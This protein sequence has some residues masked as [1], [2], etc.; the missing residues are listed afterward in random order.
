MSKSKDNSQLNQDEFTRIFEEYRAKIDAIT[1]RTEKNLKSINGIIDVYD[2]PDT[3][4]EVENDIIEEAP[5]IIEPET[6]RKP[7][8]VIWPSEKE[9]VEII[10]EA[11]RKAQQIISEAEERIKKEAKRKTREQVDKIIGKAKKEAEVIVRQA[12][13]LVER[14]REEIVATQRREIEEIIRE[15]TEKARSDTREESS[16][17]LAE[18]R[19]KA[20]KMMTEIVTSSNEINRLVTE[21]VDRAKNTIREFEEKLQADTGEL[22]R[23]IEETQAKLKQATAI[24]KAEEMETASRD[25]YSEMLDNPVLEVRLKGDK[26][27]ESRGNPTM[28]IGQVEMKAISTSFDYQYLKNL[29]KY[30]VRIHGI[31]YLQECASEK[32]MTVLFD[33]KEPLPLLDILTNLPMVD[34]V[35]NETDENIRLIFKSTQ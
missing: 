22:A 10:K 18:A 21:I 33:I 12:N 1:R 16:R 28:F 3:T 5:P 17:I 23:A 9:S 30:L 14:E 32:E 34:E 7:V 31:K 35:I 2:E 19:S 20:E 6:D 26:N 15:I 29:K 4:E 8:E 25:R 11:K 27:K 13:R 24:A